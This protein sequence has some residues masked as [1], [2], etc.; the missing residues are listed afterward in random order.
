MVER[1]LPRLVLGGNPAPPPVEAA[2]PAGAEGRADPAAPGLAYLLSPAGDESHT[3][4]QPGVEEAA[5]QQFAASQHLAAGKQLAA[6]DGLLS[7]YLL[8]IGQVDE[9]WRGELRI[10]LRAIIREGQRFARTPE[11]ARWKAFLSDSPLIRNGWLA[12]NASGLD[13]LLRTEDDAEFTPSELWQ[14]ITTRLATLEIEPFLT[15]LMQDLTYQAWREREVAR[16]G[17]T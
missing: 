17:G 12:W 6:D 2:S 4:Q 15:R 10:L 8:A 3:G 1:T 7:E 14:Q 13:Y 9:A 11:G 16:P 5:G